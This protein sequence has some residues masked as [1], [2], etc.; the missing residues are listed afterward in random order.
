MAVRRHAAMSVMDRERWKQIDELLD[1]VLDLHPD[2]RPG[3]LDRSCGGDYELRTE[4]ERLI[5]SDE[6][7]RSFIETP[8]LSPNGKF[9]V[10]EDALRPGA[11]V[12]DRFE[13][14]SKLGSGGM[15][16]V[17]RAFDLKLRV[18]VALK[19]VRFSF[20]QGEDP[21][22]LLRQ[23][24]RVAREVISPNVCRIFDL[25]NA[26]ESE[27][28]SMELIDGL[29]LMETLQAKGTLPLRDA[30]DIA[31]QFLGGLDAIH[32]AG[33]V[34]RDLKPENIM[35][36]RTG[37][38][39]VMDLGIARPMS[40][41]SGRISGT[42][43]YMSPEQRAGEQIEARSDVYSAGVVLAEMIF[44]AQNRDAIWHAIRS[45][46]TQLPDT[47]W[48]KVI[49]RAVAK[50][51]E[52]RF[53]SALALFAALEDITVRTETVEDKTPYPGLA[54]FSSGETEFFFGREQEVE[55]LIQKLHQLHLMAVIGPSGAGKTSFLRAGVIPALPEQWRC[56]ILSPG[57]APSDRLQQSV[58][59]LV[60]DDEEALER[61]KK[62]EEPDT[63]IWILRRIKQSCAEFVV[64][65][66]QFEELFTLSTPDVQSQFADFLRRAAVEADVRV[67]LSMRDDF[68]VFCNEHPALFPIFSE[69]TPLSPL[70]GA[71]LR[72]ALVQPALRCGYRFEDE[73]LLHDILFEVEKER[74]ALPLLAFSASLLWERRNR[75]KAQLT[76]QAYKDIGGVRGALAQHAENTIQKI[77]LDKEPVVHE[78]FRN[79]VTAQNTRIPRDLDELLSV[80][81]QDTQRTAKEV[82]R[83][84]IDSRLLTSSQNRI[85]VTH[86]SLISN[87]PRLVKWRTQDAEIAQMRD[88]LR[89]AAQLWNQRGR[90]KDLLW[91]GT[92][93]LEYQL[94]RERY[95][96]R[97]TANEKAFAE[98]M[99]AYAS[100]K[101]RHRRITIAAVF[102]V[103]LITLLVIG[104]LWRR[105]SIA[106]LDAVSQAN[107]ADATRLLALARA[108]PESDRKTILAYATTSLQILDTPDARRLAEQALSSGP[109]PFV[110]PDMTG[111]PCFSPDDRW[112]ALDGD[113]LRLY[114]LGGGPPTVVTDDVDRGVFRFTKDSKYLLW[115]SRKDPTRIQIWSMEQK[116]IARTIVQN[117]LALLGTAETDDIYFITTP[118]NVSAINI[119]VDLQL[120]KSVD[121]EPIVLGGFVMD[122]PLGWW[123]MSPAATGFG[124]LRSRALC[125]RSLSP[126]GIGLEKVL[127]HPLAPYADYVFHPNGKWIAILNDNRIQLD[128]LDEGSLKPLRSLNATGDLRFDP[129]GRFLISAGIGGLF[130]WDLIASNEAQPISIKQPHGEG[131]DAQNVSFDH[132]GRWMAVSWE[133]STEFYPLFPEP[134]FIF[135]G[136]GAAGSFDVRFLPDGKSLIAD[137]DTEGIRAWSAPGETQLPSRLLWKSTAARGLTANNI[138]MDLAPS[139]KQVIADTNRGSDDEPCLVSLENGDRTVLRRGSPETYH[140][141]S[142]SP[143]G[144]LAAGV[145]LDVDVQ[146]KDVAI[147]IWNLQTGVSETLQGSN[148][149]PSFAVKFA[150]DGTLFTGDISGN[151]YRWDLKN[152]SKKVWRVGPGIVTGIA[153]TS[154]GRYIAVASATVREWFRVPQSTSVLVILDL[155]QN[156]IHPI[157]SHGNRVY[158]VAFDPAGK[159]LVSGDVD[160]IVR[161]GPIDGTT[162]HMFFGEPGQIG[163][164]AVDPQGKWIAAAL[165]NQPIVQLWRMP[166]D[167]P[168]QAL[169]HDQLLK[170]L[171]SFTNVRVVADKT[172]STGYRIE[173]VPFHGFS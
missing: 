21:L 136:S 130:R 129:T 154:D 141:L 148:G 101:R 103:L 71:S 159:V 4:L 52:D 157:L 51:K 75:S 69:V 77:G 172:S 9:A 122:R 63:A 163:D 102:A 138:F 128:S 23:E 58:A 55:T 108:L 43:P 104:N 19:S 41:G 24:V 60:A 38:V 115:V 168:L 97:L 20:L 17:W 144:K 170:K 116:K 26:E 14:R 117:G 37:R 62:F 167:A 86:E 28:I 3:F 31:A 15:G 49:V 70:S 120:L 44:G 90:P 13:I 133:R 76:W 48:K 139:G 6:R 45:D 1:A 30:I 7:A 40:A 56:V 92:A 123:K 18:E 113:D 78:M 12:A 57:G 98:T 65:V 142:Y 83:L 53:K 146:A 112:F 88:E 145:G 27:L 95:S 125:Y 162:P 42:T 135:K 158:R 149:I 79:L 106:R 16:H 67:I 96:G 150:P 105:E 82:L 137:L 151:L 164:V 171:L 74:G 32:T 85:E 143:D 36:T 93:F 132:H 34:H 111:V 169:P 153:V 72:R 114:P 94:W 160:G 22:E 124:Y 39:V 107:R 91:S 127:V 73:T 165:L 29:T 11:I 50:R 35:I 126:A 46:P 147:E 134:P 54:S 89:Q 81:D 10:Q 84:F 110:V 166:Q 119:E 64:I 131:A 173:V 47:E 25:V 33:L 8:V 59:P 118:R 5:S 87:W 80:F 109:L 140:G 61:F 152:H 68:F 66:D 155:Q 121:G 156:K 2:Q 99:T 161:V 100:R